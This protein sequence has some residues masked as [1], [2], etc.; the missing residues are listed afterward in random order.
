MKRALAFVCAL[1]L[2]LGLAQA[3]QTHSYGV[4]S[5]GSTGQAVTALQERLILAGFLPGAADGSYGEGTR[6]AVVLAQQALREGGQKIA[7][8]GIAGPQTQALLFDDQVMAPFVDFTL[9]ASGQRVLALQNRLI[10]LKFLEGQAD[11]TFGSQTLNAL[12][13]FQEHLKRHGAPGVTVSGRVDAATRANLA[14]D[15]DLSGYQIKAPEF[16]DRSL[17]L[18]LTDEYLNARAAILVDMDSGTILYGK[19]LD[20]RLYPASTTKMMTLLL[21]L[22]HGGL[23]RMVTVPQSAG[24]VARDSSLVPVYPGEKMAFQDLLFGLMIRSGNDAANAVAEVTAGSLPAFVQR[25]NDKA[26]Q[27]GM[28]NSH[29]TNPHGYH[30]AEH[31]STARDLAILALNAMNNRE[32]AR[33]S[34]ATQYTM[35]A[36]VKRGALLILNTNELLNPGSPFYYEGAMGI[37]SGY[38]GPAGFCYVGEAERGGRRLLAVILRSRTRNRGWEDMASLFE[39]GFARL[40]Q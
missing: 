20:E 3:Q 6:K 11:G 21:A 23:D 36:T 22:E 9:G 17:P 32:F 15:A 8:D 25:M 24:E 35:G 19:N 34:T 29:F 26:A 40:A 5:V 30:Q 12:K 1:M 4:L 2:M 27:L 18:S 28:K 16:F 33:I 14:A 31:Y 13:S 38:T 39:Y 37:K 7:V 10:D